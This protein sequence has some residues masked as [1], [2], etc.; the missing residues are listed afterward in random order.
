MFLKN[1]CS[2]KT[3]L[4]LT[5]LFLNLLFI[6]PV[7]AQAPNGNYVPLV[8]IPGIDPNAGILTYLSGL[9]N[10]LISIVGILAMAVII[11]G[12]MRYLTS[13]GNPSSVEEAKDAITSAVI[14]LILALTSWV[15]L[16]T[17]NPDILVLKSVGV[18]GAGTGYKFIKFDNTCVANSTGS[19]IASN[20]CLCADGAEVY[21]TS[22]IGPKVVATSI[23]PCSTNIST[24]TSTIN[25]TFSEALDPASVSTSTIKTYFPGSPSVKVELA[26]STVVTLTIG[27]PYL[28][29][30]S[31]QEIIV[32]TGVKS[33]K[34]AAMNAAS[35]SAAAGSSPEATTAYDL[36]FTTGGSFSGGAE[37]VSCSFGSSNPCQSICSDSSLASDGEFHCLKLVARIG[38]LPDTNS[39]SYS[40]EQLRNMA[41]TLTSADSFYTAV[42]GGKYIID[43]GRY[44]TVP[45]TPA[46]YRLD[47]TNDSGG[48]PD[49]VCN[50]KDSVFNRGDWAIIDVII[51]SS[52]PSP[53]ICKA[54]QTPQGISCAQKVCVDDAV[55]NH[56]ETTIFFTILA[57]PK[58]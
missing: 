11:Y 52:L 5:I 58:L 44:S 36:R 45:N 21:S 54:T 16:S 26:S 57:K 18:G 43:A 41:T 48:L 47:T 49:G 15:I 24:A 50:D 10:F 22:P 6:S 2:K 28:A 9:Y 27:A 53:Y 4:I 29:A 34:G 55:G 56:A 38:A 12:G 17:I 25:I 30:N 32:T 19:G 31:P 42:E 7:L 8:S 39:G 3:F 40:S 23:S 13:A 20:P 14:G 46:T 1:F 33:A 35:C 37:C 51:P